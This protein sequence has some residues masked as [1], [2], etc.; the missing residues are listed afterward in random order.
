VTLPTVA[1]AYVPNAPWGRNPGFCG[2]GTYVWIVRVFLPGL[3]FLPGFF[4]LKP[5]LSK[6]SDGQLCACTW[7]HRSCTGF[8]VMQA[9]QLM[10]TEMSVHSKKLG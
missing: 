2:M 9:R 3:I 8:K 6:R 1:Y 4:C 10:P 5:M 7:G